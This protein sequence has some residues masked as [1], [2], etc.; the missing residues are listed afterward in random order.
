VKKS[1]WKYYRK[2]QE[3]GDFSCTDQ[4][5]MERVLGGGEGREWAKIRRRTRRR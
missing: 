5:N 1:K 4:Y 3:I 2:K